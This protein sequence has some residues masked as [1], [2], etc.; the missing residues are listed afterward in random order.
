MSMHFGDNV[1][2]YANSVWYYHHTV[3]WDTNESR[4]NHVSSHL[5]S[6]PLATHSKRGMDDDDVHESDDVGGKQQR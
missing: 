1:C 4:V 5:L 2:G 3:M 6:L